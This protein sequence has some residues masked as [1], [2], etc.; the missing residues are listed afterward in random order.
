MVMFVAVVF[1]PG[2]DDHKKRAANLL[3]QYGFKQM[4][5]NVFESFKISEKQLARLKLDLD[6]SCDFYDSV[7]F[8]QYPM[9]DTLVVSSL[10]EKRWRK[11][12][13][14]SR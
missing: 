2:S 4:Q 6:R 7:R 9:E 13:V 12:I 5:G 10:L 8:Y 3:F 1:D 11:A 14:K